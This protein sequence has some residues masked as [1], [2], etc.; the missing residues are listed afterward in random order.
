MSVQSIVVRRKI[1]LLA[2]V[3]NFQYQNIKHLLDKYLLINYAY[4]VIYSN[5]MLSTVYGLI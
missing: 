5:P 3:H 4:Q 2:K 1:F